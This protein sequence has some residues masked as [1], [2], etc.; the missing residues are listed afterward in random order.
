MERAVLRGRVLRLVCRCIPPVM[1]AD[2]HHSWRAAI[3]WN[4]RKRRGILPWSW[5]P[6]FS[7]FRTHSTCRRPFLAAGPSSC[8]NRTF[9]R[10]YSSDGHLRSHCNSDNPDVVRSYIGMSNGIGLPFA[11]APVGRTDRLT[12]PPAGR[13]IGAD[14]DLRLSAFARRFPW[15]TGSR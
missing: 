7:C 2:V 1:A 12:P 14:G 4:E 9:C 15:M 13:K 11:E 5:R 6:C 10:R 3:S 8:H